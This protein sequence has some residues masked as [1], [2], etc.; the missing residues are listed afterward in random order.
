MMASDFLLDH[1]DKLY[2]NPEQQEIDEKMSASRK[3]YEDNDF[4]NSAA[5]E[6]EMDVLFS[7]GGIKMDSEDDDFTGVNTGDF[8]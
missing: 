3:F 7:G 8:Y 5:A 6:E 1:L 4:S 2:G